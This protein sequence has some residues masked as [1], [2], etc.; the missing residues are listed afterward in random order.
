MHNF[1]TQWQDSETALTVFGS[2]CSYNMRFCHFET[3]EFQCHLQNQIYIDFTQD[4]NIVLMEFAFSFSIFFL[5]LGDNI[6]SVWMACYILFFLLDD[7]LGNCIFACL[8]VCLLAWHSTCLCLCSVFL[9]FCLSIMLTICLIVSLLLVACLY[10]CF[11]VF[12][13]FVLCTSPCGSNSEYLFEY[14][15]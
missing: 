4:S 12:P 9:F 13:C 6:V 10:E 2:H 7:Y 11:W 14:L 1:S 3:N 5:N 8:F 15:I